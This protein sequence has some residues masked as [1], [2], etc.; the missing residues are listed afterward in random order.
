MNK[1]YSGE[2]PNLKVKTKQSVKIG[3]A[4]SDERGKL[5]GGKPGD[6]TG[7]EVCIS[8]YSYSPKQDAYNHWHYVARAKNEDK[9]KIMAEEMISICNNNK[10]GYNQSPKGGR[11]ELYRQLKSVKW[12]VS[13]LRH[14]TDTSCTPVVQVCIAAS[15]IKITQGSDA[16]HLKQRLIDTNEFAIYT[17]KE[18]TSK[19]NK[20]KVG[21]ILNSG[22]HT[23]MVVSITDS[24]SKTKTLVK[25]DSRHSEVEKLQ[26]MLNWYFK[27]IKGK[28]ENVLKEKRNI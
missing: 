1:K 19:T 20:L 11:K 24:K 16:A 7:K 15:G 4:T 27:N 25:G 23:A 21:D 6:Q 14:K 12:K 28:K 3:Q 2:L 5:R 18:Y 13:K 9:R 22:R 8:K 17:T 26:K 10:I